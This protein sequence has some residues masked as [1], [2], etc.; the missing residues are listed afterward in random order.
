M[1]EVLD[2]S[3]TSDERNKLGQFATPLPL[4]R[5]I[6]AESVRLIDPEISPGPIRFL[7]PAFG[8]GAFWSA[9]RMFFPELSCTGVGIEIDSKFVDASRRLWTGTGLKVRSGDFTQCKSPSRERDR[10]DLLVCNPPYV[11]HHHIAAEHKPALRVAS[12]KAAGVDLSGLAGLYCH[13]LAVAHPWMRRGAIAAWLIPTEFMDVNYGTALKQYLLRDVTLARV[14]QFDPEDVQ[15]SDALVSSS[16]VVLRN[17][18]PPE[19][20]SVEFSQGPKLSKVKRRKLVPVADLLPSDRW[21]QV[22]EKRDKHQAPTTAETTL[23]LDD[24]FAIRRGLVTGGNKFFVLPEHRVDELDLPREWLT[25]ILPSPRY[26]PDLEVHARADGTPEL[27]RRY[28]LLNC[29]LPEEQIADELPTLWTYLSTA[30][31]ALRDRYICRHRSPWYRQEKRPAAPLVC[32]YLGRQNESKRPFRFLLNHSEATA[33]NVYHMLYPRPRLASAMETEPSILRQIWIHLN[34]VDVDNLLR[35]SR[36]YG[37]G[38]R[39]LEPRELGRVSLQ[40]LSLDICRLIAESNVPEFP[41]TDLGNTH[42][43][44]EASATRHLTPCHESCCRPL[45]RRRRPLSPQRSRAGR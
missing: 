38:L 18:A 20:H 33:A 26:V 4:A 30:S 9:L 7:D 2:L 40:G 13:F 3:K 31:Q 41:P 14:H 12:A 6:I 10:F 22:L 1:Q 27:G 21:T 11:R 19:D 15:F 23:R 16:V 36:V 42:Q 45:R 28:F 37:G 44:L 25:P 34:T 8:T 17:E 43:L 32:T 29:D 24:I 39:K 35:E 5:D